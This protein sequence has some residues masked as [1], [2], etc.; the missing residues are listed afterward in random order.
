[1]IKLSSVNRRDR[2]S[3][4]RRRRIVI[5]GE[6][7]RVGSDE[8]KGC[9]EDYEIY[10]G[11]ALCLEIL[12]SHFLNIFALRLMSS[13]MSVQSVTHKLCEFKVAPRDLY[14]AYCYNQVALGL[15]A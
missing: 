12:L 10:V 1:M 3:F 7:W 13:V 6:R 14:E 2:L 8:V 15:S 9:N 4:V 11:C 5:P